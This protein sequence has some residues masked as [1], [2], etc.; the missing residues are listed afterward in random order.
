MLLSSFCL[1]I[2]NYIVPITQGN[3]DR[4]VQESRYSAKVPI[5]AIRCMAGFEVSD[6]YWLPRGNLEVPEDVKNL[7]WPWLDSA[8]DFTLGYT[9]EDVGDD[10]DR[11]PPE[12]PTAMEFLRFLKFLRTVFIQDMAAMICL[13]Q[14]S[15]DP[16]AKKRLSHDL[17]CR[18]PM[19]SS[20]LFWSFTESMREHLLEENDINNDPSVVLIDRCLPG[21]NKRFDQVADG[22]VKLE[23][24]MEEVNTQLQ[25]EQ[26]N[27]A[28]NFHQLE[29]RLTEQAKRRQLQLTSTLS[30]FFSRGVAER[31]TEMEQFVVA[32]HTN[33][34]NENESPTNESPAGVSQSPQ[35][36][37]PTLT[38]ETYSPLA[39][40][41]PADQQSPADQQP[42]VQVTL[43]PSLTDGDQSVDDELTMVSNRIL[44]CRFVGNNSSLSL[45]E[46]YQ[47]FYG[48]EAYEGVPIAGGFAALDKK[49]KTKWRPGYSPSDQ[50]FFSRVNALLKGIATKA[51]V[52]FGVWNAQVEAQ[53]T[54]W[55]QYVKKKGVAGA[56]RHLQGSGE[57]AKKGKRKRTE[58]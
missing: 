22:V 13:L 15:E 19:F 34:A 50:N 31:A 40:S 46:I 29:L 42:T 10:D 35:I 27:Q 41:P 12:H 11:P 24:S 58:D 54:E 28:D 1:Y 3:W 25:E 55:D 37:T 14:S 52:E 38:V 49:Y 26:M 51:G 48:L 17:F 56:L 33:I 44:S 6:G 23:R 30:S 53:C 45:S 18:F 5:S 47:E 39:I 8:E 2:S 20:P 4:D 43:P 16:R 7:V 57:I 36:A 21:L 32:A 9:E